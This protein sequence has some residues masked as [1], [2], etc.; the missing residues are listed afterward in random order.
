MEHHFTEGIVTI[1]LD[2]LIIITITHGARSASTKAERYA[3]VRGNRI[4]LRDGT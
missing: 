3:S 4:D 2:S 1:S